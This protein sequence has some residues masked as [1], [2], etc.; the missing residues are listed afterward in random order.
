MRVEFK[1]I[2]SD[3]GETGLEVMSPVP[4]MHEVVKEEVPRAVTARPR[5]SI[6]LYF[7]APLIAF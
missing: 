3:Y 6:I 7:R 4:V 2:S 5:A 1:L